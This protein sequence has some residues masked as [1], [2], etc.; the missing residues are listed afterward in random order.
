MKISRVLALDDI[1]FKF[2][3]S[4]LQLPVIFYKKQLPTVVKRPSIVI[5]NDA[6]GSSLNLN[7]G[8]LKQQGADSLSGS[9][10]IRDSEPI[11]QAYAGINSG[12][13]MCLVMGV[14]YC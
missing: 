8:A 12:I 6:L 5:F 9:I 4:Y 1:G 3:N 14:I 2:D 10:L 7:V 13:L 11:A